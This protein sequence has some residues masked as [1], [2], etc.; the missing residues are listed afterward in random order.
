MAVVVLVAAALVADPAVAEPIRAPRTLAA[1]GP[2]QAGAV[3]VDFGIQYVGVIYDTPHHE[4]DDHDGHDHGQIRVRHDGRWGPWI[5]LT[6]D[7]AQVAG[8]WTSGLVAV[9]AGDAYQVRGVPD[10][11]TA[12]RAVAINTTDGPLITVG[13]QPRGGTAAIDT[14]QCVTRAQWGA[15]ESLMTWTPEFYP[16]QAI[17]VHH[18]GGRNDNDAAVSDPDALVRAIYRYHAVD[19]GWGDIG[20]QYLVDPYGLVYEGRSSGEASTACSPVGSY[21]GDVGG[22]PAPGDGDGSDFAHDANGEVVTAAH[23]AGANSGNLGISV[24]GHFDR[25]RGGTAEPTAAAVSAVEHLVAELA[26]RHGLDPEGT[27]SYRNPSPTCSYNGGSYDGC[28][29]G[30]QATVS[31]HRDW[32]ATA[33]PGD[34]L[35]ALLPDIRTN[36]AALMGS[37]TD[38]IGTASVTVTAP[39][40]G[41]TV[42]GR[43][44]VTAEATAD[45]G[46]D[47]VAFD[48]DGTSVG[49]DADGTDGY[50]TSVDTTAVSDGP[51][52]I[53]ATVTAADGATDSHSITVTVDNLADT[54]GMH[55]ADLDGT[56]SSQGPEWTGR[57]MIT[58]HD[59]G[60]QPVVGAT[61]TGSWDTGGT[62]AC[63]TGADG[64]CQVDSSA[65]PKR[66]KSATYTVTDVVQDVLVYDPAANTDPDGD[67]DGTRITVSH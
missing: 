44:D 46:V 20:Y 35:Y 36:A 17:T 33:C 15:D 22:Q 16:A 19:N 12:A 14:D 53:T 58:V 5:D 67:S 52:T 57:V 63:T 64:S 59:G 25:L 4:A 43:L 29:V 2:V 18:T 60:G 3:S 30:E 45:A 28:F 37:T 34:G 32:D 61:V 10:E 65:M 13:H 6:P 50:T 40:D 62:P 49:T 7:G 55:V 56:A 21:L 31:G 8:T 54:T 38:P 26:T 27:I 41:S 47:H 48:L 11:A 66:T 39:S 42:S 1:G 9:G 51:H 23:T 24:L